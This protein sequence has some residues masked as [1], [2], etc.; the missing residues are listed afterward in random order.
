M[1]TIE[2]QSPPAPHSLLHS[3][4]MMVISSPERCCTLTDNTPLSSHHN[5]NTNRLFHYTGLR[6]VFNEGQVTSRA[7]A[8]LVQEGGSG[9]SSFSSTSS[10][11]T[12]LT[13]KCTLTVSIE[14]DVDVNA[15]DNN[16]HAFITILLDAVPLAQCSIQWLPSLNCFSHHQPLLISYLNCWLIL[17]TPQPMA[18]LLLQSQQLFPCLATVRSMATNNSNQ[19]SSQTNQN[20][21]SIWFKDF[22]PPVPVSF[23]PI[24]TINATLNKGR[25]SSVKKFVESSKKLTNQSKA[26]TLLEDELVN[27]QQQVVRRKKGRPRK[28]SLP[29]STSGTATAHMVLPLLTNNK[30]RHSTSTTPTELHNLL[31]AAAN[32]LSELDEDEPL[33]EDGDD[34]EN[35]DDFYCD[36]DDNPV[37]TDL[38]FSSTVPVTIPTRAIKLPTFHP[39]PLLAKQHS[40]SLSRSTSSSSDISTGGKRQCIACGSQ[41]TPLWRRG[42]NGQGT[43]C[44][45]C[46]VKWNKQKHHRQQRRRQMLQAQAGATG[47]YSSTLRRLSSSADGLTPAIDPGYQ[48]FENDEFEEFVRTEQRRNSLPA[49]GLLGLNSNSNY[50]VKKAMHKKESPKTSSAASFLNNR[51]AV[52]EILINEE[53]ITHAHANVVSA[54]H[55]SHVLVAPLKKR[56]VNIDLPS[57]KGTNSTLQ[58]NPPKASDSTEVITMIDELQKRNDQGLSVNDDDNFTYT[59]TH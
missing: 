35:E 3:P 52:E 56:K 50:G 1:L 2:E 7:T 38:L 33:L 22:I 39:P 8:Q 46:G 24:L 45:A 26:T 21:P 29:L 5:S 13:S 37:G 40:V 41:Q 11:Y 42:P 20:V 14:E 53:S 19:T 34:E 12:S 16:H 15:V 36:P 31:S 6:A 27:Q 48:A 28:D 57:L 17:E 43:L 51:G 47:S 32:N 49:V 59:D 44:N 55:P 18:K 9:R 4:E 58:T 23:K 54:H 10:I 25:S 30:R